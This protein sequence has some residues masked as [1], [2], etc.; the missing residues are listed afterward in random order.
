MATRVGWPR[1]VQ[2]GRQLEALV[3]SVRTR[4]MRLHLGYYLLKLFSRFALSPTHIT[5][6][7]QATRTITDDEDV[8][9]PLLTQHELVDGIS[10]WRVDCSII[11]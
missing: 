7:W 2:F 9:F 3:R 8:E 6:Q 11:A 10:V 1:D 5:K 4:A